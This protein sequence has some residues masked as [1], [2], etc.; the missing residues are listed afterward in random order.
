MARYA[1]KTCESCGYKTHRLFNLPGWSF[2]GICSDCLLDTLIDTAN[3]GDEDT[4]TMLEDIE[5]EA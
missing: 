1:N 2:Y 4:Q 3:G 5:E